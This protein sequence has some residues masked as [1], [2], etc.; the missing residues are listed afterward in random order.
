MLR[1]MKRSVVAVLVLVLLAV[2]IVHSQT[3]IGGGTVVVTSVPSV[4]LSGSS[5][6]QTPV[7]ASNTGAAVAITASLPAV[8]GKF[9]Y[10]TGFQVTGA[11]AT[12]AS[13]VTVTVT[14]TVNGTMSYNVVA[15]AG[16]TTSIT[17]LVVSFPVP[18]PSSAVNTAVVVNVPSLGAGNTNSAVA[19]QGFQQ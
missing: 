10:I 8:S 17:Q 4:A 2:G 3:T 6:A 7:T 16:V 15:P 18:V 19:A 11:G 9:T 14:G 5:S 1:N 12:A 13:V